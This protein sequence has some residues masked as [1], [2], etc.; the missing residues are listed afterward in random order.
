MATVLG[1][2]LE[3]KRPFVVDELGNATI[4]KTQHESGFAGGSEVQF[5][6]CTFRPRGDGGLGRE[7]AGDGS[8]EL[9]EGGRHALLVPVSF[10]N[11]RLRL[12]V[13]HRLIQ[14]ILPLLVAVLF[15]FLLL[16]QPV[17]NVLVSFILLLL[18]KNQKVERAGDPPVRMNPVASSFTDSVFADEAVVEVD[19]ARFLLNL[20]K[21]SKIMAASLTSPFAGDWTEGSGVRSQMTQESSNRVSF[22]QIS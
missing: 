6:R 12:A 16:A 20:T 14:I 15:L 3:R 10:G 8:H 1:V 21:P 4:C 5:L 11:T 7:C 18:S 9:E 13:V 19:V 17:T 22:T 2:Q